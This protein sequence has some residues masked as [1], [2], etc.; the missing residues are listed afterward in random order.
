MQHHG[1]AVQDQSQSNFQF[2]KHS[3]HQSPARVGLNMEA[4]TYHEL[5]RMTDRDEVGG[6]TR[7]RRAPPT[8]PC[9]CALSLQAASFHQ[10]ESALA[11]DIGTPTV[12]IFGDLQF[13]RWRST[14]PVSTT[15]SK[16]LLELLEISAQHPRRDS[17]QPK[18]TSGELA[19]VAT[20]LKIA[21][22]RNRSRQYSRRLSND[23]R[24]EVPA[25]GRNSKFEILL[26][27]R[28]RL[29]T[30]IAVSQD[31]NSRGGCAAST[32]VTTLLHQDIARTTS[33]AYNGAKRQKLLFSRSGSASSLQHYILLR[34]PYLSQISSHEVLPIVPK[35]QLVRSTS[36]LIPPCSMVQ[37]HKN[38]S[39]DMVSRC[40]SSNLPP[41]TK[42]RVFYCVQPNHWPP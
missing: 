26:N 19:R 18:S 24:F 36:E 41:P 4:L 22:H 32:T 31:A 42:A 28:W 39:L 9:I 40:H 5:D 17:R 12:A 20:E 16:T 21:R 7:L 27:A 8:T 29:I 30:A 38:H 37:W 35:L 11:Y 15:A 3:I 2:L 25:E 1:L 33:A 23:C 10:Q 14:V 6:F 13:V 34:F